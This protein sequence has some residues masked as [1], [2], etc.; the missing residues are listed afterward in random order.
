M[1]VLMSLFLIIVSGCKNNIINVDLINSD[2]NSIPFIYTYKAN[3]KRITG[4]V[5]KYSIDSITGKR[6]RNYVVELKN[7]IRTN[8]IIH[9]DPNGQVLDSIPY[10]KG[11]ENG[12]AKFFY[13]NG[14]LKFE[15]EVKNGRFNGILK[16]YD[17]NGIQVIESIYENGKEIKTTTFETKKNDTLKSSGFDLKYYLEGFNSDNIDVYSNGNRNLASMYIS[18]LS[19]ENSQELT[20]KSSLGKITKSP[21]NY[22]GKMLTIRGKISEISETNMQDE[23]NKGLKGGK[24][25]TLLIQAE[26]NNSRFGSMAID[27]LYN[28]DIE[29]IE[30]KQ[31]VSITGYFVGTYFSMN[32]Y[33]GRVE[34][35]SMVGNI[36]K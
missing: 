34:A 6:Y 14:Q 27:F 24:W 3:G 15:S 8:Y 23:F 33:G 2:T 28:G 21:S 11:V 10:M 13:N 35:V 29:K 22:L 17:E 20:I 31:I 19:I 25:H 30:P 18:E 7:G 9:F 4:I 36:V 16:A 26:N 32:A 1:F 5:E 12:K